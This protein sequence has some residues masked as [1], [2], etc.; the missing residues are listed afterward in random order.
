MPLMPRI[1]SQELVTLIKAMLNQYPEKR[2]SVN[3]IL[4]DQYI[5]KN[6][7]IFLEGTRRKAQGSNAANVAE[8]NRR[9]SSEDNAKS[10]LPVVSNVSKVW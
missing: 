9:N 2:P 10:N 3:R 7:A 4:R 1:Y 5:K 6:I 8:S